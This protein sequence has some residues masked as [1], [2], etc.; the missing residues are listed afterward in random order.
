MTASPPSPRY[1]WPARALVA[2]VIAALAWATP[3]ASAADPER[4]SRLYFNAPRA[5]MLACADCHGDNPQANNFGNVWSGRNAPSLIDRAVRINTG[6]MAVFQGL[7]GLPEL[8]DIAAFLGN[9]P[10]SLSFPLTA[11][12]STSAAQTIEIATSLKAPLTGL[13]LRAEGDFVIAGSTC[14]SVVDRFSSCIVDVG[15]R[16]SSFGLRSGA[17]LIQHSDSATPVRIPLTG[18]APLRP[19]AVASLSRTAVDFGSLRVGQAGTTQHVVLRNDSPQALTVAAVAIEGR[20]FA[21]AGGSCAAG[22]VLGGGQSC[23]VALQ[24]VPTQGGAAAG[25]LT[26]RH[27]GVG[28]GSTASLSG[29]ADATAAARWAFDPPLLQR[30]QV[31]AGGSTAPWLDF[32][33]AAPG[34]TP[35]TQEITLRNLGSAAG[36][37]TALS[38]TS[39]AFVVAS[40]DCTLGQPQPPGSSCSVRVAWRP[41]RATTSGGSLVAT[42]AGAPDAVIALVGRAVSDALTASLSPQRQ[43]LEAAPGGSSSARWV[44]VNEGRRP[45]RL[46]TVA[47][48]GAEAADFAVA[49][50]GTSCRAGLVV[51]EGTHC[52]VAVV[53]TPRAVGSRSAQLQ[54]SAEGAASPW[55]AEL[56]GR[57][58][59]QAAPSLWVDAASID[60]GDSVAEPLGAGHET[61]TVSNRGLAPL[62]WQQLALAGDRAADF[63]ITGGDCRADRPLAPG[64]SC[65]IGLAFFPGRAD[66]PGRGARAA[67]VVLW[68]V[69]Q[70]AAAIVALRGQ[71]V[72]TPRPGVG[73]ERP[74]N[75]TPLVWRA[76]F[77]WPFQLPPAE[78]GAVRIDRDPL[79]IVINRSATASAPLRWTV[80]GEHARDFSI[81]P[82]STCAAGEPLPA[83]AECQ[84]HIAFHPS[85]AGL[86]QARLILGNEGTPE[87]I[88]LQAQGIAPARPALRL[89]PTAL[90]FTAVAS[91]APSPAQTAWLENPGAALA[92]VDAVEV[93]GSGLAVMPAAQ[94]GDCPAAP[95]ELGAGQRC[96]LAVSWTG[97]AS[98]SAGG[99]LRASGDGES[100]SVRITITE[101]PVATPNVGTGGG[102]FGSAGWLL[103]MALLSLLLGARRGTESR[104]D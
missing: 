92:R 80:G 56:A 37:L 40:T 93:Q 45:L 35:P 101:E 2:G 44:L 21:V 6:G 63:R 10:R 67:S 81:A 26:I 53:F 86:R 61:L 23:S 83:Q 100:A 25:R 57:G 42:S 85:A 72:D 84:L 15:F 62:R 54:I 20:D 31:W 60:F 30:G 32:G 22:S 59:A 18:Q 95:F 73:A 66:G 87:V 76:G 52:S 64:E 96:R 17:L 9:L 88:V 90:V 43:R 55:V 34:D 78:V 89:A 38:T 1:R 98:A 79:S 97:A 68:P 48:T 49:A 19:P 104:H 5:G 74:G 3:P 47:V 36:A 65:T 39:P 75:G 16:P 24:F 29:R 8:I 91:G 41:T 27:D 102:A 14:A 99:L 103:G 94:P 11:I 7:Y 70:D 51:A 33:V 12:G 4:G 28:E 69:G 71:V 13:Q 77:R 58:L 82:T 50:D 46:G